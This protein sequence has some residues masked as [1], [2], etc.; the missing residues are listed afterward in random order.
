M[1]LRDYRWFPSL[2]NEGCS[3]SMTLGMKRSIC[4]CVPAAIPHVG[5]IHIAYVDPEL[6][7]HV[8]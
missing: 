2:Q 6:S 4:P 8:N 1:K 7:I 5:H 3:R